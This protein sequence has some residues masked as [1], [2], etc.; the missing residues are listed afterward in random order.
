[1]SN[2]ALR[3]ACGAAVAKPAL[4]VLVLCAVSVTCFALATRAEDQ[5]NAAKFG[6][7]YR[8]HMEQVPALNLFAGV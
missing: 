2:W 3:S 1:V 4:A 5:F 6:E 8:I 7:P